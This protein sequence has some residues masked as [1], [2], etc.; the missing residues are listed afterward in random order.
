MSAEDWPKRYVH[1]L[2]LQSQ[3]ERYMALLRVHP[4]IEVFLHSDEVV[5]I[6]ECDDRLA[7]VSARASAPDLIADHVLM[8]TGH[9]TNRPEHSPLR[10]RWRS[11]AQAHRAEFVPSAYPLEENLSTEAVSTRHTVGCFGMGLTTIDVIL[12][13]TEGRGGRF[14]R[15]ESGRLR[16]S[17]SGKEPRSIIASSAAGLFTFARPFNAKE[18]DLAT[19]EHAGVF[20]TEDAVDRLRSS[21]GVPAQIGADTRLQLNFELHVFPLIVLEM[22]HLYYTTLLG[23]AFGSEIARRIQPV[24]LDF[25]E[26]EASTPQQAVSMLLAP[27]EDAANEAE[28]IING[29]LSGSVRLNTS[30]LPTWAKAAVRRYTTVIFGTDAACDP[31][32][33]T[34]R[35]GSTAPTFRTANL[36]LG[37]RA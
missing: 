23:T 14:L 3:F 35:P 32:P 15:D 13:L 31:G 5:D 7:I 27:V 21:V 19:F 30:D 26:N 34:G 12:Y 10:A 33:G 25:L 4:G 28:H 36:A 11:F 37:P 24:Y 9:S 20:L 29:A 22:A 8:A 18:R 16:Y 6:I 1:G 2:A 17:P